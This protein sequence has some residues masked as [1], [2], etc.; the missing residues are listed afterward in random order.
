M[1]AEIV[2]VGTELLLGQ[3]AN[4]NARWMSEE[5][6][7]IGVDVLHH[8]V[9]GDNLPRIVDA[10]RLA[11]SRADAVL[12]TGGLGPTQDDLTR[13]AVAAAMGVPL[14][15][16]PELETWLRERFAGFSSSP[17]PGSNL[18]Q[19]D[20]P[21]GAEPIDNPLG[22]APGLIA[23]LGE[24]RVYAV[25][26]VPGEMRDMMER[27]VLPRLREAAGRGVISSRVLRLTGIGESAVAELLDD[28]FTGSTNPTV[29]YLASMG[30]VKV[31]LTA[32]APTHEGA[33]RLLAP[34]ADEVA[35]RLGDAVFTTEDETLEEVVLRL[36]RGSD[37]TLACAESLTGGSVSARLAGPPG[38]SASLRGGVVAY[39]EDVKADVLG[40]SVATLEGPGVVSAECA[41]EMAA[42]VRRLLRADVGIALTGVAGPERHGGHPPGTVWIALDADDVAHARGLRING[43][44]E[45]VVRWS[46][47]A[48]LDL[49]RRYLDGVPLPTSS[50]TI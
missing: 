18:R 29:A 9:V 4:T 42:G 34:V 48:A 16:R 2:A 50:T 35:A 49:A 24:A 5:L 30:E 1:R 7:A 46:Q 31:R 25:P 32:K 26:G 47:Q 8:Q 39:Q 40:V 6:A 43:E 19:A 44:R 38:A 36:L 33:G 3:I 12:V 21:K 11:S 13:D 10:L 20:V 27:V 41:A 28:L 22:S 17:M 14:I 45:R 37:R 15:R 23:S